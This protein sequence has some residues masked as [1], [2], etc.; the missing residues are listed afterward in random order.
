MDY[1]PFITD[2]DEYGSHVPLYLLF[3]SDKCNLISTSDTVSVSILAPLSSP[4]GDRCDYSLTCRTSEKLLKTGTLELWFQSYQ[5][6]QTNIFYFTR[7][8]IDPDTYSNAIPNSTTK[9]NSFSDNFYGSSNIIG[10]SSVRTASSY[11]KDMIPKSVRLYVGYY[12]KNKIDKEILTSIL[13][14]EEFSSDLSN[15]SYKFTIQF[16]ALY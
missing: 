4:N 12:Q 6:S 9:A 14:F 13:Y 16:E 3:T 2:C 11:S 1:L 7:K 5:L 10:V 15:R 8:Q